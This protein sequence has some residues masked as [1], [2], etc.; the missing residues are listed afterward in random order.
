MVDFVLE[1]NDRFIVICD[2]KF[3]TLVKPYMV[4]SI[5]V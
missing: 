3:P 2:L 4:L 1:S 5:H